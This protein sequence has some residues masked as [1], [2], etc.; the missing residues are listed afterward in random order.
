MKKSLLFVILSST[1]LFFSC[2]FSNLQKP[3]RVIVKTDAKYEFTVASFDSSKDSKFDVSKYLDVEKMIK[4]ATSDEGSSGEDPDLDFDIYKYNDGKSDFQ[5]LLLHM[6]MNSIDFDFGETF[7]DMDFSM[8][9]DSMSIDKDITIPELANL[10]RQEKLD[11]SNIKTAL[12]SAVVFTGLVTNSVDISVGKIN[13]SDPD[14]FESIAYKSGKLNVYVRDYISGTVTLYHDGVLIAK[15][16][17]FRYTSD[18]ISREF[19][20]ISYDFN[21]VAQID[22]SG[23]SICKEG[24]KLEFDDNSNSP[25]VGLIDTSSEIK[26]ANGVNIPE[27]QKPTIPPVNVEFPCDLTDDILDCTIDEGSLSV[28]ILTPAT[29]TSSVIQNYEIAITESLN[30]NISKTNPSASLNGQKIKK[31]KV[32]ASANM[33]LSFENANLDFDNPPEVKINL[34]VKKISATVKMPDN[35]EAKVD[36]SQD[37][38]DDLKQMINK[39]VWN[40]SGFKLEATTNLPSGNDIDLK[41]SSSFLGIDETSNTILSGTTETQKFDYLCADGTTTVLNGTGALSKFDIQGEILLPG[42]EEGKL[43]ITN[44]EPGKTYNLKLGITPVF[45]WKEAEISN[46]M[47]NFSGA[48]DTTIN[49]STLF[50]SLE[51]SV[52]D[53]FLNNIKIG[54]LPVYL[55]TSLPDLGFEN[56]SFNGS[57]KAYYAKTVEGQDKPVRIDNEKNKDI[58][59]VGNETTPTA[60]IEAKPIPTFTYSDPVKKDE[61]TND[62]GDETANFKDCLNTR[63]DEGTLFVDYNISFSSGNTGAITITSDT[64][65]KLKT[66]GKA[67]IGIDILIILNMNFDLLDDVNIDIMKLANSEEDPTKPKPD[68]DRDLLGRESATSAED[69]QQYLDIVK[70]AYVESVNT[71]LPIQSSGE[72]S[73]KVK[74]YKDQ[75]EPDIIEFGNKKTTKFEIEPGK[76]LAAENYPLEPEVELCI[77]I[78]NKVPEFV[79]EN[80]RRHH[81]LS[82]ALRQYYSF[83]SEIKV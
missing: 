72:I 32:K 3:E 82:A 54:E 37:I 8:K 25:F 36:E 57:I 74:M 17:E 2:G 83:V 20:G 66:N 58:W 80:E 78:L 18:G 26:S 59:I 52:G 35:F 11:L 47:A 33:D 77:G 49:M 53:D 39:I 10:D 15:S 68:K 44:V 13:P 23:V 29:W 16:S 28:N 41:I 27:A 81:S 31:G 46:D 64:L 19:E 60:T 71:K 24:L 38:P 70:S 56:P 67:S 12:N 14:P 48:Y 5:Q 9:M 69:Y 61:V 63:F 65:E 6:P 73:L 34:D 40:A 22:L 75:K 51:D 43:S 50:K 1:F 45:D 76:L 55:Y 30:C 7:K 62:F 42:A 21:Y 4:E 79:A